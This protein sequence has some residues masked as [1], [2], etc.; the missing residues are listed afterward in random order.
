MAP[1]NSTPPGWSYQPWSYTGHKSQFIDGEV[2]QPDNAEFDINGSVEACMGLL[3]DI[4][5]DG[6]KWHDIA[7]YHTKPYVCEDSD[8]L[9]K[10]M[11]ET[12]QGENI[13]EPPEDLEVEV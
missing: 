13:P 3:N 11:R 9:L 8:Q 12:N 7:C 2:A 1:T 5:E 6:V 10:Y 4:Y